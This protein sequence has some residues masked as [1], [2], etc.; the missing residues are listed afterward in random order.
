[1][2]SSIR[3]TPSAVASLVRIGWA[4]EDERLGREVV[5]LLRLRVVQQGDQRELVEEIALAQVDAVLEVRDP[6]ELIA[7]RAADHAVDRIALLEKELCEVGAILS[8]DAG[9]QGPTLR[10]NVLIL[11]ERALT[12]EF[13]CAGA[14]PHAQSSSTIQTTALRS[15]PTVARPAGWLSPRP[16]HRPSDAAPSARRPAGCGNRAAVRRGAAA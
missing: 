3:V 2:A 4:Q 9:D 16:S 7:G 5:D 15:A 10:H 14:G 6:L 13:F 12:H 1:M 11:A 8:G